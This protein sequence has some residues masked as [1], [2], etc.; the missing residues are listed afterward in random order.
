MLRITKETDY[1][2]MLLARLAAEP[3]GAVW[4]AREVSEQV[5]L[6]LPMVSKILRNLA[7]G[8]ILASHR[9]ASGGYSLDR[10]PDTTSVAEVVRAL[11]GPIALVQ[12]GTEPGACDQEPCCPTRTIWARISGEIERALDRIPI[13]EMI[14]SCRGE[15]SS[16]VSLE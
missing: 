12:C 5:G 10:S 15:E 7:R 16:L 1:G 8:K 11:E 9:G 14:E 13:S 3:R 4:N 2:V 6:P